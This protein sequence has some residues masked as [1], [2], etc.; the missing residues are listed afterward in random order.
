VTAVQEEGLHGQPDQHAEGDQAGV[1]VPDD[2]RHP[3]EQQRPGT[4]RGGGL[5]RDGHPPRQRHTER[6]P[7]LVGRRVSP[8]RAAGRACDR[9]RRHRPLTRGN[10]ADLRGDRDRPAARHDPLDRLLLR[11]RIAG[12]RP[13][14]HAEAPARETDRGTERV[15]VLPRVEPV[16]DG[17]QFLDGLGGPGGHVIRR[18][19]LTRSAL[20]GCRGLNRDRGLTV[21]LASDAHRVSRPALAGEHRRVV[22]AAQAKIR[23]GAGRPGPLQARR[24]RSFAGNSRRHRAGPLNSCG[25]WSS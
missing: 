3:G 15:A 20:R 5:G 11:E 10:A 19:V 22:V 17:Q 18:V 24:D 12:L 23:G 2:P 7:I 1:G 25:S 8:E 21:R 9:P 13:A 14:C 4:D 6:R 16:G